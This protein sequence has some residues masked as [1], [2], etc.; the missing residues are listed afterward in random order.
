MFRIS[1]LELILP[2]GLLLLLLI[3]PIMIARF[4]SRIDK[5]LKNIEKQI[6]K[7]KQQ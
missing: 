7:K 4:Y 2:C 1:P 5:R 6:D 3:I